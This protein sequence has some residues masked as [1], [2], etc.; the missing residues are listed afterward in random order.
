[1]LS[2]IVLFFPLSKHEYEIINAL[3]FLRN[4]QTDSG[5][6]GGISVSAWAAIAIYS[7][8]EDPNTWGGIS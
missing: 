8:D 6:I 3:D 7:A 5:S 4:K 2:K 1:M